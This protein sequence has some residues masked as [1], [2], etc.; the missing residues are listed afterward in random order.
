MEW[1]GEIA[2]I[3]SEIVL[4]DGLL[5]C[6]Q[7]HCGTSCSLKHSDSNWKQNILYGIKGVL[8]KESSSLYICE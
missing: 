1:V 6:L 7:S 3:M 2:K 5:I 8:R 4:W